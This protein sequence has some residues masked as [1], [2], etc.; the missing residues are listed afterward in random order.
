MAE[1]PTREGPSLV[2]SIDHVLR[3]TF[4]DLFGP[5]GAAPTRPLE[6][7]RDIEEAK[8]VCTIYKFADC[9]HD[10]MG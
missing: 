3:G 2:G 1:Q 5:E 7:P 4:K 9:L 6:D 10:S 8:E